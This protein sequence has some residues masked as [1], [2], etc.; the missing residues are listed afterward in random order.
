MRTN[1]RDTWVVVAD[2]S[3]CRVYEYHRKPEEINLV[4]ELL[5]PENQLKDI[6][7]GHDRLG[8]FRGNGGGNGTFSPHS[9]LKKNKIRQFSQ[10]I[11]DWL[12]SARKRN[13]FK[14]L[15]VISPPHMKGLFRQTFSKHLNR[16]LD[17][18]IDKD[19]AHMNRHQLLNVI[20]QYQYV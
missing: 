10:E 9:D 2:A 19:I 16:M 17:L 18:N 14:H 20:H 12:E 3:S 5:H 8:R 13:L 6:D 7:L 4:K 11:R 1:G 15:V